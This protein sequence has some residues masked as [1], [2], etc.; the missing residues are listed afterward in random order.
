MNKSRTAADNTKQPTYT[1]IYVRN[2]II[3]S[4]S[5]PCREYDDRPYHKIILPT[6]FFAGITSLVSEWQIAS[7]TTDLSD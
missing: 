3:P 6:A 5:F 1:R 2:K 7:H 4:W